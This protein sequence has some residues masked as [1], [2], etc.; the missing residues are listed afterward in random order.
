MVYQDLAIK[1]EVF[2]GML[3]HWDMKMTAAY[4]NIHDGLQER[5]MGKW[6]K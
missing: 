5:E 3:G 4:V 2:Q 1:M 6:G